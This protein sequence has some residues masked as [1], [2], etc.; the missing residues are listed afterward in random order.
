MTTEFDM[1]KVDKTN[2]KCIKFEDGSIY[3][4]DIKYKD[5]NG[6]IVKMVKFEFV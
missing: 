5:T 2:F 3:Y 4:G 6:K 1:S